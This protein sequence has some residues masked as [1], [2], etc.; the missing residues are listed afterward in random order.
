MEFW[1]E[2][3][4]GCRFLL[5]NKFLEKCILVR[6]SLSK[7][8]NLT[9]NVNFLQNQRNISVLFLFFNFL[10]QCFCW[11]FWEYRPTFKWRLLI[12][13]TIDA[14][15]SGEM[16]ICVDT[17]KSIVSSIC[18]LYPWK[19]PFLKV[20][21]CESNQ[22]F[23]RTDFEQNSQAEKSTPKWP[24]SSKHNHWGHTNRLV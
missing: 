17:F 19:Y 14:F 3:S 21:E 11:P 22:C 13:L 24:L 8:L 1:G 10:A 6:L 9:S 4:T 20:R 23:S 2:G 16:S 15:L 12:E 5:K 7:C 18:K